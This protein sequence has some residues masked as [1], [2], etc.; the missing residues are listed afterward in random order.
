MK[1]NLDCSY[2]HDEICQHIL[3]KLL[4]LVVILVKEEIFA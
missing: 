4:K 1:I 2:N 3:L